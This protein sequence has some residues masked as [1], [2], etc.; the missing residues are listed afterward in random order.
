[1]S[2]FHERTV[3]VGESPS[4]VQLAC[5]H[6]LLAVPH[7]HSTIAVWNLINSSSQPAIL[8]GHRRS[9]TAVAFSH[10]QCPA[11]LCSAAAADYVITWSIDQ[12]ITGTGGCVRGQVLCPIPAALTS[13]IYLS[14][15]AEDHLIAF[16]ADKLVHVLD[17]KTSKVKAILE[18]HMAK[19]NCAEFCPHYTSTLVSISDDRTFKVWGI[20][21]STLLYQSTI[22]SASPFI[23]LAMN[24]VHESFAIGSTDGMVRVYDMADG[25]D[26]RC[27]HHLN[28]SKLLRRR[29]T[30]S[31]TT[32][33]SSDGPVTI[34][35]WRRPDEVGTP[36][37]TA[38]AGEAEISSSVLGLTYTYCGATSNHS[39]QYSVPSLLTHCNDSVVSELLSATPTL[40]VGVTG[41]ILQLD[42][43]SLEPASVVSLQEAVITRSSSERGGR[44][45][46]TLA[47][48]VTFG[49]SSSVQA[50]VWCIVG[51]L[52]R[53]EVDILS[54]WPSSC[55][56]TTIGSSQG[57]WQ[58]QQ[59]P[60]S[61]SSDVSNGSN[62]SCSSDVWWRTVKDD[63]VVDDDIGDATDASGPRI[64]SVLSSSPL[65]PNSPL[66]ADLQPKLSQPKPQP[67]ANGRAKPGSLNK[68]GQIVDKQPLTF[69]TKIK[70][71]GYS[72]SGPRSAMFQPKLKP[73]IKS[74][75]S[76]SASKTSLASSA[77][78]SE[79]PLDSEPPLN[80]QLIIDVAERPT[81]I[82]SLCFSERG[83]NMA[84][85]LS[86]TTAAIFSCQRKH[87]VVS[88]STVAGHS[89]SVTAANWSHDGKLLVTSS[90]DRTANVWSLGS[91][92]PVMTF[93][94]TNQSPAKGKDASN[95]VYSKPVR[96]AQFYYVDR[97][98]MLV[99]GDCFYLYK[100]HLDQTKSDIQRY[101]SSTKYKLV[102]SFQ[103][104]KAQQIS[105]FSAIN[106]F[107]SYISFVAGSDK[108]LHMYDMNTGA[109]VRTIVDAHH[110]AVHHI[111]Q[112]ASSPYASHS[113]SVYDLFLT[114]AVTDGIKLWDLRSSRH[115]D[116]CVRRYDGHVN[117]VH[118]CTAQISPCCRYVAAAS[119]DKC[120]YLYDIRSGAYL[121]KLTGHTETVSMVAFHPQYPQ[122]VTATLDG[123]IRTFTDITTSLC[124]S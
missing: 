38:A 105:A 97:F 113:S 41:A 49:Q 52:F 74:S 62:S 109:C 72:S 10:L 121:H 31:Q 60:A 21:T 73:S 104:D 24:P 68:K 26:F 65:V 35:R 106:S 79:Y 78:D 22:I 53:N 119:E 18:G 98:I 111:A 94:T 45:T 30:S 120:A 15:S 91:L 9:V 81:A 88:Q 76:P 25:H 69:Q 11:L 39:T 17:V 116:R 48:N 37:T 90:E 29:D 93:T 12:I 100:Y 85:A 5:R 16:C 27:L 122:L 83:K 107:H 33:N 71:S 58:C 56:E 40:F 19:V 99:S 20:A 3:S 57:Q 112:N 103:L 14:F 55:E 54:A 64:L 44:K 87:S 2:A 42:A 59:T 23:S 66:K 47:S 102:Q 63:D 123:K 77:K 32:K 101:L 1:M 50:K 13:V 114:C 70:S 28:I 86:N 80:P 43:T 82:N 110:R 61:R 67:S 124:S 34:S 46:L 89:Q 36:D 108:S 117:R 92:D 51:K 95:T 118:P 115:L 84:C 4:Q 8:E 7:R 6:D 75:K 96:W